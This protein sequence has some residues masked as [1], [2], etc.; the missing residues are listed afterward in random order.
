ML[1]LSRKH[2][3]KLKIGDDITV[4]VLEVKGNRAKIGIEAPNF[5]HV[6]RAELRS[7][8]D[9][10]VSRVTPHSVRNERS[11]PAWAQKP[12]AHKAVAH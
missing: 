10:K 11:E 6:V 7:F 2:G 8:D 1:V 4:T 12:V 3:E 5:Y 9:D